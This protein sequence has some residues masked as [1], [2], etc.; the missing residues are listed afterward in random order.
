MNKI[1][2]NPFPLKQS[3][4]NEYFQNVI[5]HLQ[6]NSGRFGLTDVQISN[7]NRQLEEWKA[8][9]VMYKTS[10]NKN[11]AVYNLSFTMEALQ[12]E[13]RKIYSNLN[14]MTLTDLDRD[15]LN[16]QNFWVDR[17]VMRLL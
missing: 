15:I 17:E 14:R 10:L 8:A 4:L 11:K 13:L 16:L 5:T 6:N 2:S 7:L 3:E 12:S 1:R 9:Y